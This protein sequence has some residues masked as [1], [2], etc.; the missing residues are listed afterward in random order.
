MDNKM[1]KAI[2]RIE[3]GIENINNRLEKQEAKINILDNKFNDINLRTTIT[4]NTIKDMCEK[5]QIITEKQV[6]IN[7]AFKEKQKVLDLLIFSLRNPK[8]V[9]WLILILLFTSA[10]G[11]SIYLFLT[12]I[13]EKLDIILKLLEKV[14]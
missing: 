13:F 12:K 4:E 6:I 3:N 5:L 1:F 9:F 11:T 8:R 7:G 14:K 10:T 2:G